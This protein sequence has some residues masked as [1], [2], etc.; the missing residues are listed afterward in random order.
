MK[1]FILLSLLS[2]SSQ[3][4]GFKPQNG[5]YV[6]MQG[7]EE[8]IC[9][10]EVR[11][12]TNGDTLTAIRVEYVGWC[13]SMGPYTYFCQNQICEDAGIKFTFK[14]PREYRWENK[15]YGFVCN[16]AKKKTDLID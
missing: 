5:L 10:Q 4:A 13:G 16:F 7:N 3:A 8:S 12:F 14:N 1:R 2:F 6:C 9:D 11:V 15:Q